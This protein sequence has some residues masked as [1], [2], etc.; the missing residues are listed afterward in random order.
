MPYPLI[1]FLSILFTLSAHAQQ[2]TGKVEDVGGY[3]RLTYTVNRGDAERFSPPSLSDFEILSGPN[4]SNFSSYQLINGHASHTETT[5]Y[6]YILSARKSG[7]VTIGSATVRVGNR[8]LRSRSITLNVQ[9]GGNSS[10]GHSS[11]SANRNAGNSQAADNSLQQAGS[12]VTQRDLYIDVTPSRTKVREQEA[13]LLT[14]RIH[15]RAGVGLANTQLTSKPDFKGLISQEIP[16][17]GNQIQTTIE[18]RNGTTYRT[19]TILQYVVFPQ[20]AG[21][22][23]IPP[24]T[25]DCTVVQQDN[26]M[27]LA[28]AFFNGG[29]RIGVQVR[30]TVPT[31]ILQVEALPLPKPTG[32][33][34]AVGRF[35]L[36]GK[37]LTDRVRTN[38]IVTYRLTLSGLGN[39][40]LITPPTVTFPK[41]FDTYDPKTSEDTRLTP[42]GL[43]GHLTFD[44]TFVPRNVGHYTIPA[45]E[46]SY[47]DTESNTYR[48]L[49]TAPLTLDISKGERSNSDVDRQLALLRSDIRPIHTD[50]T[51]ASLPALLTWGSASYFTLLVI[52]I[53]ALS[54]GAKW[55]NSY[56]NSRSDTTL[57]RRR[58]AGRVA[59]HRLAEARQLLRS[60]RSS[61]FYAA[62]NKALIG[63][64]TD[65][66]MLQ[67][68]DCTDE[69]IRALLSG[70]GITPMAIDDF[71]AVLDTCRYAQFAP[72][73]DNS[74]N[75]TY[76]AALHALQAIN[77][78]FRK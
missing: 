39:L 9:A 41:D 28:D 76:Q 68:T 65:T 8:V 7:R 25:F 45:V 66:F 32:F 19:G 24:I 18:H 47:F 13:V 11:S 6:T 63:Y 5:S 50:T 46:F 15:A 33:S 1:L 58:Q 40:K 54:L 22:L 55:L 36:E 35:K 73:N 44:Y 53:I 17:P 29:G 43:T 26:T 69:R 71:I 78:S 59:E 31:K 4:T 51:S 52:L 30:R 27:D 12:A 74:R 37:L 62:V 3:Y 34:G 38:D 61:D 57:R 21:R 67:Q 49:R 75:D 77:S 2:F 42:N 48:T 23:A 64:L 14:Y 70:K 16:L 56:I 10:G 20:Q 72:S 60:E